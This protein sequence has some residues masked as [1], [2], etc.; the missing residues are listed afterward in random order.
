LGIGNIFVSIPSLTNENYAL[1]YCP[2]ADV[3]YN[4]ADTS[5]EIRT[6]GTKEIIE[7]V[8]ETCFEG[9]FTLG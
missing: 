7:V 5:Q 9:L 8:P 2:S 3:Q 6:E 1:S 4:S